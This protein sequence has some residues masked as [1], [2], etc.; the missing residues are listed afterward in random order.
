MRLVKVGGSVLR[1]FGDYVR[2][3]R[4]AVDLGARVLIVSAMKGVTDAL[5]NAAKRNDERAM[6][7]ILDSLAAAARELGAEKVEEWVDR[8]RRAFRAYISE[9]LPSLLDEV[10]AVGERVST[11]TMAA[12]FRHLGLKALPLDGGE[13]GIV[14][15]DSF[16]SATPLFE[17]CYARVR[18]RVEP[19]LSRYDAIV[20][21]G[22]VGA[23]PDGWTTTMG[24]GASDLTATIVARALNADVLYL[25]TDAPYL[26]TA[27]PDAVPSARPLKLV[28]VEEADAMAELGVKRFHPLTFKP[29]LG[30]RIRLVVGSNP[31]N[32]SLIVDELA[33]PE[34]KVVTQRG[35]RVIFVGYGARRHAKAVAVDLGLPL[36]EVGKYHFTLLAPS[37][38][39]HVL[40]RA[41]DALLRA[42]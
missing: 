20:I 14:T 39:N 8:G 2:C 27:D 35:N 9:P 34:L 22:F 3:A 37:E 42:W 12:A 5:L 1:G 10:L 7:E 32:G 13:A 18:E 11:L 30:S 41:H 21:A 33:P 38:E 6:S 15:D 19:L 26:M 25:V 31:P 28:G 24:R 40:S 16:G 17:E 29:I 4:L 23:T 36:L